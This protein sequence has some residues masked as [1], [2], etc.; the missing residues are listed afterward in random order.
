[1]SSEAMDMAAELHP[2][3]VRNAFHRQI[4]CV[5]LLY[6]RTLTTNADICEAFRDCFHNLFPNV[7]CLRIAQFDAYLAEFTRLEASEVTGYESPITE[8]GWKTPLRTYVRK[9]GTLMRGLLLNG[10]LCSFYREFL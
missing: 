1:M 2:E 6:N 3:E 4:A 7:T 5:T 9:K 10:G 8:D